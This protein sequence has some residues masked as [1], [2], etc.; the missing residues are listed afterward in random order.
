MDAS[1]II[2]ARDQT[3]E[4]FIL[5]QEKGLW[6]FKMSSQEFRSFGAVEICLFFNE[7]SVTFLKLYTPKVKGWF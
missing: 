6:S 2:P 1:I 4:S 5:K 7:L 3:Q